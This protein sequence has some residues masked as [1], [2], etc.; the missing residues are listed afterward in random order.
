LVSKH[1]EKKNTMTERKRICP[2]RQL[3]NWC[4]EKEQPDCSGGIPVHDI[5]KAT[6][7]I[8]VPDDSS[9]LIQAKILKNIGGIFGLARE[10][11]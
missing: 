5:D 6:Q 10:G 2:G 9:S 8:E 11:D 4:T 3:C 7:H 1:K